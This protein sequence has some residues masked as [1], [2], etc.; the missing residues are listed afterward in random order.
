MS[1][2]ARERPCFGGFATVFAVGV[3]LFAPRALGQ[4]PLFDPDRTVIPISNL[5]VGVGMGVNLT[6]Q[7]GT[8]FCLNL[9]CSFVVTNYHVAALMGSSPRIRGEKVI[10]RYSATSPGDAGSTLNEDMDFAVA[11]MQYNRARDLAIFRLKHPLA[12][13]GMSGVTF[14]LDALE[15]NQEVD[16]YAYPLTNRFAV[17]R[18]LTRFPGKFA[19]TT[20]DGVLVF[21]YEPS[22]GRQS[23]KPG[24][25]GGLVVD[26]KT[27]EAVGVLTGTT[28]GANFAGAVSVQSLA[29]FIKK[30]KPDLYTELFPVEVR[31]TVRTPTHWDWDIYGRYVPTR[32][33]PGDTEHRQEE[34]PEIK[35]LRT[36]AQTLAVNMKDFIAVQTMGY[37]GMSKPLAPSQYEIRVIDG[38]QSYREYPD[39]KKEMLSIPLPKSLS[40]SLEWT[41]ISP[42]SEWSTAVKLVGTELNLKIV[43]APDNFVDGQKV[44]VFQY[45]GDKEDRVCRFRAITDFI[46]FQNVRETAVSCSGEVWTDEDFNIIRISENYDLPPELGWR[47]FRAA[48]TYGWLSKPGEP[49]RLIPLRIAG[50]AVYLGDG[51]LYWFRSRFTNYRVFSARARLLE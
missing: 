33:S 15:M 28:K 20:S 42:G 48:V 3:L 9:T 13:K 50:Q 8:G 37:G 36:N 17:K 14:S 1:L 40:K 2:A 23:M 44:K 51:N 45:Y 32:K 12:S 30:V 41:I 6:A 38:Q 21:N 16:L 27:R 47:D 39:G 11:P 24:M 5:K 4:E 7:L 22:E 26:R 19:G 43:Q 18:T 46:L 25:S 34:P 49:E 35:R 31:A 29:E 10:E